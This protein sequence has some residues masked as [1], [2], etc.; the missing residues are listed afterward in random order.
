MRVSAPIVFAALSTMAATVA[1]VSGLAAA[2][3]AAVNL[4]ITVRRE[5]PALAAFVREW[6][7]GPGGSE[8]YISVVVSN[9][10]HRPVTVVAMG[11]RLAGT[12]RSLSVD[13]GGV[14]MRLPAKLE[15]G[16]TI[17]M[18]WMRDELGEAYWNGKLAISGCYAIDGRGRQVSGGLVRRR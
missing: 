18:T 14:S 1:A 12:E 2:V 10:G 8:R 13:D 16:E 9:V 5:A 4:A 11:L 15:D 17:V 7:V 3:L 6:A